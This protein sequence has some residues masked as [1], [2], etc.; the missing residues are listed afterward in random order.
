M[1]IAVKQIKSFYLDRKEKLKLMWITIF[2]NKGIY[3]G[4]Y[5]HRDS[6]NDKAIN[7]TKVKRIILGPLC[8][9]YLTMFGGPG[10]RQNI[11]SDLKDKNQDQ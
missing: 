1:R 5:M 8:G 10:Q 6:R 3:R 4:F 7:G 11:L 2:D 9:P